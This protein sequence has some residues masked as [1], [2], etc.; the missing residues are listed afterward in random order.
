LQLEIEL[1]RQLSAALRRES[2]VLLLDA[3]SMIDHDPTLTLYA[4]QLFV[5]SGLQADAPD[6]IAGGKIAFGLLDPLF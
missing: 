5:E 2:A 1:E 3:A 6:Q 4:A